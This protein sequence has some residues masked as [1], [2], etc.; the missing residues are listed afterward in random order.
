MSEVPETLDKWRLSQV[1]GGEKAPGEEIPDADIVSSLAFDESGDYLAAGDRGGR[2]VVFER[3]YNPPRHHGKSAHAEYKFYAE[4]QSHVSEFDCLKSV[5]IE[6]KINQIKFLPRANNGHLMLTTNNKT[7]KLWKVFDQCVAPEIYEEDVDT[8]RDEGLLGEDGVYVPPP[9]GSEPLSESGEPEEEIRRVSVV[10]RSFANAHAFHINSIGLC[11]DQE[12]F[13]SADDLRINLWSLSSVAESFNLVDCKPEDLDDLDEVITCASCHPIDNS[14]FLYATSKGPV[15][16]CD[17]RSAA[18]CEKAAKTFYEAEDPATKSYF[19]EIVGSIGDARFTRDG[20]YIVSRDFMTL[21]LWDCAMDSHPVKTF[22]VHE[23]LRPRL[24]DLYDSDSIF[25]RF[26]A[27]ANFDGSQLVT[28]SFGQRLRVYDVASGASMPLVASRVQPK[29]KHRIA[30]QLADPQME[31]P[32]F[33]R[34][35][36][37]VVF[38]PHENILALTA[39]NNLFIFS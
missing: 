35:V 36:Q 13:I 21:K 22:T 5:E 6:A 37:H 2:I 24:C 27:D 9:A 39:Q 11:S 3:N 15:H 33:G 26:E 29:R 17:M 32:E 23:Y 25:D 38:H 10:K 8:A 4:F 16:L 28:G 19:S 30:G 7:V 34:K 20:R 18:L 1:F 14:V 31:D 12:N